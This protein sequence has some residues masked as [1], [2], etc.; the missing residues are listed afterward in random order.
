MH[1]MD[2]GSDGHRNVGLLRRRGLVDFRR[3]LHDDDYILNS[4]LWRNQSTVGGWS[5]LYFRLDFPVHY[6]DGL[7]DGR[8]NDNVRKR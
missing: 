2:R 4:W 1:D 6:L 8:H 3:I 7:L 5:N